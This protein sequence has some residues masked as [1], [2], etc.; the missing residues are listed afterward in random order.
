MVFLK[1]PSFKDRPCK[2]MFKQLDVEMVFLKGPSL[3]NRQSK[4]IF[5]VFYELNKQYLQEFLQAPSENYRSGIGT[6]LCEQL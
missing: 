4:L 1:G 5:M 2:E 3:K 6:C